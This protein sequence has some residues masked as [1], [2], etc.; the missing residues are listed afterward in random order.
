M[1]VVS[2]DAIGLSNYAAMNGIK[3]QAKPSNSAPAAGAATPT[4]SLGKPIVDTVEINSAAPQQTPQK[5]VFDPTAT[6][7]T[8]AQKHVCGELA[9][10]SAIDGYDGWAAMLRHCFGMTENLDRTDIPVIPRFCSLDRSVDGYG[11]AA[12]YIPANALTNEQRNL[13]ANLFVYAHD[14]GMN[15]DGAV[16]SLASAMVDIATRGS[17]STGLQEYDEVSSLAQQAADTREDIHG[18]SNRDY[19]VDSVRRY[20]FTTRNNSARD[21]AEAL[22]RDEVALRTLSSAAIKDNLISEHAIN[23]SFVTDWGGENNRSLS[24]FQDLEKLVHAYSR[25]PNTDDGKPVE[26]SPLAQRYL[27]WR[28]GEVAA[29]HSLEAEA[30]EPP[31]KDLVEIRARSMIDGVFSMD[32]GP[33]RKVRDVAEEMVRFYEG[34]VGKYPHLQEDQQLEVWK[35]IVEIKHEEARAEASNPQ[36][37]FDKYSSRI[38]G[39]TSSLS[40][41]QK[42]VLTHMYKLAEEKGDE[43]SL[44]KVDALANAFA[45]NNTL[46]ILFT[47]GKDKDGKP[48]TNLLD[49]MRID[50]ENKEK[51]QIQAEIL[52]KK[53]NDALAAIQNRLFKPPSPAK[54]ETKPGIK[55]STQ[56]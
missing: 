16:H 32:G 5:A 30:K 18:V 2:M 48:T 54:P 22:Q 31:K 1:E 4:S 52:T 38:S 11:L 40:G 13:I 3:P 39:L 27:N 46:S 14:H 36:A 35:R 50:P 19:L 10:T 12:G 26:M 41:D 33:Y 25:T 34:R 43:A 20:G 24:Q 55:P 47:P 42:S 56:G 23:W 51:P 44:R 7:G 45:A 6:S 21:D 53:Y 17:W 9:T 49:M 28:K 29:R 8:Y 37:A 15:E